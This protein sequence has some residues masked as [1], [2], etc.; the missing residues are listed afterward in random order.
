[1]LRFL[2]R[3]LRRGHSCFWRPRACQSWVVRGAD[4]VQAQLLR[5]L[6][7]PV[8]HPQKHQDAREEQR[9]DRGACAHLLPLVAVLPDQVR[10]CCAAAAAPPPPQPPPRGQRVSTA[11]RQSRERAAAPPGGSTGFRSS[12]SSLRSS[13]FAATAAFAATTKDAAAAADA[14]RSGV[15]ESSAF[16][17]R[18]RRGG[19]AAGM[20]NERASEDAG[21]LWSLVSCRGAGKVAAGRW[22]THRSANRVS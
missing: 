5:G 1:M 3:V 16:K 14:A 8:P 22:S 13:A 18:G 2:R 9:D 12:S 4:H 7:R 15:R 10:R 21:P 20:V 11:Q 6:G 17:L 19:G